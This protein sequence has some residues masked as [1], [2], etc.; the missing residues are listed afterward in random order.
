MYRRIAC[1]AWLLVAL[2][3]LRLAAQEPRPARLLATSLRDP[4]GVGFTRE[5]R[6][7]ADDAE[8]REVPG[9]DDADWRPQNPGLLPSE[10]PAGGW[11]GTG[12]FR[13]HFLVDPAVQRRVLA[14][15]F[16]APG[17][18]DVYLDGRLV[19]AT[20]RGGAPPEVPAPRREACL[21]SLKGPQH[22]LAVRYVYPK[23]AARGPDG[24]GFLLSFVDPSAPKAVAAGERRQLL[25]VEGAVLALPVFLALFHLALFAF[26]P[27]ARENLFYSAF[28]AALVL[29]VLNE[30]RFDFFTV[31]AQRNVVDRLGRVTPILATLF[32]FF[33]YYSLRTRPFPRSWRAFAAAGFLLL[34]AAFFVPVVA[35]FGW[36][37]LFF[38]TLVEIVRVERSGRTVERRGAWFVGA[39][40][41]VFS[42]TIVL[43]IL[44][45]LGVLESVAGVRPVYIFGII[46][47]AAG[48]SLYLASSLGY[49]RVVEAENARKGQ[50]LARARELQLSMLPRELPRIPHLDVAAATRTAAEVGGDFYDAR[51]DGSGSLLVAFG[52]A[53]GHGLAAGI[54]VTATKAL[55]TSLEPDRPVLDLL[56]AC[57]RVLSGMRL[58]RVQMCLALARVSAS[59]VSIASAAMPPLLI[60]R[61]ATGLVDEVGA[62]GL[63]LGTRLE[64]RYEERRATLGPGDS[65]LF[66]SDG[67]AEL[68]DPRRRE[69]GFGGVA[70]AFARACAAGS[71]ADT[72]SRLVEETEAFRASGPQDDDITFLVIRTGASSPE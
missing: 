39:S 5:W 16:E 61:R 45:N 14:L 31:E 18:A 69:L 35:Q 50:E 25:A 10:L 38:A 66:A 72:V 36:M 2:P 19:L 8:G 54:M 65:L 4:D 20:G 68:R 43:Q 6:F 33:T 57:D 41:A 9:F 56:C 70:N 51:P 29:I 37:P 49:A 62:A 28:M 17:T 12:W 63:P 3:V 40:Y 59:D 53:T 26:H 27:R 32:G 58:P 22:V 7:A 34:P 64:A 11:P 42:L 52:D 55:F 13:R 60:H 23:S 24:I 30:Y 1:V 21:L 71:A 67:F 48:M 15:R 46:A 47:S 44:V